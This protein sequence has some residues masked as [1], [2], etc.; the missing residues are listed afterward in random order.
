MRSLSCI[1]ITSVRERMRLFNMQQT[2]FDDDA[3]FFNWH[4]ETSE[5]HAGVWISY[6]GNI[7]G[8]ET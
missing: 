8:F 4:L 6:N 2:C 7:M 1:D 5:W 3:Q